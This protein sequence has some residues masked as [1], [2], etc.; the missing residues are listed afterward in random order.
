MLAIF[1]N[2]IVAM[3]IMLGGLVIFHE[4]GHFLVG[5]WCGVAVETFSIGFGGTIF[6]KRVGQTTYQVSWLPLGGFV[7][8]YGATRNEDVP[9]GV[10]GLMYNEAAVWKRALI[11]FA[12][13]VANF[14]LAFLIFWVMVMVGID[15]PPAVVGDVIENGRAQAAGVLP[16]DRFVRIDGEEVNGWSDIERL[17]SRNAERALNVVVERAGKEVQ[18]T[19]TPEAVPGLSLF[20]AKSK[21]GRAGVAL[22]Y[23]SAVATVLDRD[24]LLAKAGLK[25]GDRI[26][27]FSVNNEPPVKVLGFHHL[28]RLFKRWKTE[29]VAQVKWSVQQVEVV[30][31]KDD[32]PVEK[33]VGSPRDITVDISLWPSAEGLTDRA[34]AKILGVVDSHLTVAVVR[35]DAVGTLL[36]GDHILKWDHKEVRTIYHLQEMMGEQTQPSARLQVMRNGQEV[37]L[38]VKLKPLE[39]QKPEGAVTVYVL[40]VAMLGMS[41]LPDPIKEQHLNPVTAAGVAI[42]E[43][44]MQTVMM[45]SSL[46]AIVT[47]QIPLKAL[48][49]PIMIAKVAG[50]SAKAGIMTFIAM[51]AVI[52]INLGLVN[53]FPI[54]VLDGGQLVLLAAEQI[55]GSSLTESTMENFQ[56]LGFVLVLCLIVLAMYNDLSRFWKSMIASLLGS[57]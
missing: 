24:S 33:T 30:S 36:P 15:R 40:D 20:G 21:I 3:I 18:M 45:A 5:R 31:E 9:P 39:V 14:L 22:G 48:G 11:V 28:L 51:M 47:G 29:G 53:L 44:Y 6:S 35:G 56:K 4:L 23:P 46:W 38:T 37:E 19:L 49:G 2:P 55:K 42:K 50:D 43:A 26:E 32:R 27:S 41:T 12:G 10:T 57:S 17:I 16:G 25:T 7:K 13:P 1:S 54:P 52:S 8:F 34:Y